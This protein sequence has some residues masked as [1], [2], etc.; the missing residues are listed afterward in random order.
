MREEAR[1]NAINTLTEEYVTIPDLLQQ[2]PVA[3]S[4]VSLA[5]VLDVLPRLKPRHYSIASSS[6]M[7][8][9][10]LQLS[11]GKL[12]IT[13]KSTGKS[14]IGVCSHFLAARTTAAVTNASVDTPTNDVFCTNS[15]THVC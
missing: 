14:R 13:H 11:V 5:E 7:N 8:P 2:F 3:T 6:E 4:H 12:T 10:K 1:K 15:T 9:T